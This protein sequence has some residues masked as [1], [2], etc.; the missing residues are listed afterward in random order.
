MQ[1]ENTLFAKLGCLNSNAQEASVWHLINSQ[2][3]E[4][5]PKELRL[6]RDAVLGRLSTR[7]DENS[8]I[9]D[10]VPIKSSSRRLVKRLAANS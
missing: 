6:K 7:W 4:S 1:R 3:A 8:N 2:A 5:R 9:Q 10:L